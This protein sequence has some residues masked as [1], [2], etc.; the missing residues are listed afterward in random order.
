[1]HSV[2]PL[3]GAL[4]VRPCPTIDTAQVEKYRSIL[5]TKLLKSRN[6]CSSVAMAIAFRRVLRLVCRLYFEDNDFYA[7]VVLGGGECH[8]VHGALFPSWIDDDQGGCR[9]DSFAVLVPWRRL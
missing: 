1:M 4:D 3:R 7:R 2:S 9:N 6:G 5:A 8:V